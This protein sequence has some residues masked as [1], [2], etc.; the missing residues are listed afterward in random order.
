[1]S[2]NKTSICSDTLLFAKIIVLFLKKISINL[3]TFDQLLLFK[4]DNIIS[5]TNKHF[6]NLG[7]NPR[8]INEVI[9]K[10]LKN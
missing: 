2:Q 1:M 8:N 5:N 3:I 10:L 6:S 7:I 4:E 9:K